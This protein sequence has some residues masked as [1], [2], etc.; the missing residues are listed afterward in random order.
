M[1]SSGFENQRKEALR[2]RGKPLKIQKA[3]V[4]RTVR[5]HLRASYLTR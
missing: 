2:P 4:A 1:A 3:Q 5:V